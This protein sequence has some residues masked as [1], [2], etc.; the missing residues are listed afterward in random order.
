MKSIIQVLSIPVLTA[1]AVIFVGSRSACCEH[2]RAPVIHKLGTLD[3]DLVESTPIVFCSRLY[4]F[5]YVRPN[6]RLNKAGK[7]CFR[8]TDVET[9]EATPTFAQT[10]NLGCAFAEGDTMWVFGVDNW[11]GETIAS[12]HSR[13]LKHWKQQE[14]LH[15]K[16]WGLF[17]SSVCKARDRYIMAFEV[18]RPPE[19]TGVPFTIGF[20]ESSDLQ[21]WKVMSGDHVFTKDRYSACPSIRY[22]DG[23]FYMT[24]LEARPGPSYETY[25][26]RSPDLVLWEM[27]SLNPVL[28]ASPEDKKIANSKLTAAEQAEI[29]AANDINNSDVDFCEFRGKTVIT[30][31]WGNQQGTEFLAAAEYDG[32]RNLFMKSFFPP[33]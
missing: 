17:N 5:E 27:S 1:I 30:Y 10:Y 3:L 13:D 16:G 6:Y 21:S 22:L 18:G 7:P 9:G 15:L 28:R 11:D 20:A 25:I 4:R 32:P 2:P 29:A 23:Q 14:A 24:Y 12:F 8:F 19:V 26:V 33:K 31:S